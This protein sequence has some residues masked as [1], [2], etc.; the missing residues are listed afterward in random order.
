MGCKILQGMSS[1]IAFSLIGG[2]WFKNDSGARLSAPFFLEQFD[3]TPPPTPISARSAVPERAG[4]SE[5]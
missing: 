5:L 1:E 3:F 4:S 2:E